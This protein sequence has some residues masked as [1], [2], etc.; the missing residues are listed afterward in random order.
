MPTDE[1]RRIAHRAIEVFE[2]L[3]DEE[4]LADA[5]TFLAE[6]ALNGG[7]PTEALTEAELSLD[8]ALRSDATMLLVDI[9][10]DITWS[11]FLGPTPAGAGLD[12]LERLAEQVTGFRA[13]EAEAKGSVAWFLG[14]PR[15]IRRSEGCGAAGS[16]R[17]SR[18]SATV[19][20]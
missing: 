19:G 13:A 9:T 10:M 11:L 17:C 15:A 7:K 20:A 4:G 12:R 14:A 5:L 2:E 3:G 18:S 1:A 8:Y 16:W 6:L